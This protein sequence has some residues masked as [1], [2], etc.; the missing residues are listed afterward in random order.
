MQFGMT[1]VFRREDGA[2]I[3]AAGIAAEAVNW[4]KWALDIGETGAPSKMPN[5]GKETEGVIVYL[6]GQV[7][8]FD[9]W[10]KC[11]TTPHYFAMGSGQ[12]YALGAMFA[13]AGSCVAVRAAILHCA[14]CGGEV[15]W[16]SHKPLTTTQ[17]AWLV[18]ELKKAA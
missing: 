8:V 12:D 11:V 1:K 13:G 5:I 2:L 4:T 17:R 7:L 15:E 14:S 9:R 10:G 16:V 6:D 3:G 18:R